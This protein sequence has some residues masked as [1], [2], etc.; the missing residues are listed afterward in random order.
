M[1]EITSN[2]A[3]TALDKKHS[4]K[5]WAPGVAYGAAK[6]NLR[7]WRYQSAA[8]I[9]E[10][11]IKTWPKAL[12]QPEAYYQYALA[13]E[14]LENDAAAIRAYRAYSAKYPNHEWKDQARKRASNI[15]ANML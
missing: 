12:W 1:P 13:Q 8:D 14:K 7:M 4:H 15:Q 6:I 10:D 9:L 3:R 2:M 11:S 5:S